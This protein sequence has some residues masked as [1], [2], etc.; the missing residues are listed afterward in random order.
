MREIRI[1]CQGSD[2]RTLEQL[3]PLQGDLKTMTKA[4]A[5]KLERALVSKGFRFPIFVW[6][7]PSR[8]IERIIDGHQRQRILTKLRD[9]GWRIPPLPVNMIEAEDEAEARQMVLA[10]VSQFGRIDIDELANFLPTAELEVADILA[11]Y[12]LPDIDEDALRALVDEMSNG[13]GD[14]D[15]ESGDDEVPDDVPTR[16]HLGVV[17]Q[18]GEHRL[19]CGDCRDPKVLKALMQGAAAKLAVHDPPYGVSIVSGTYGD[20]KMHG[21]AKAKRGNYM[22]I[23]GDDEP[24]DP[25]VLLGSAKTV[26]IWGGNY[27]ADKLPPSA[28]WLVWDKRV[29]LPSIAFAD[30]ELAWCSDDRPARVL[31]YVWGGFIKGEE[32]GEKRVHPTQKPVAL[33]ADV[34]GRYTERDDIVIDY[35]LGSGTTL[36]ACER[37]A[38]ICY[39]TELEPHYCD[40][41]VNRWEKL[42]GKKAELVGDVSGQTNKEQ[43]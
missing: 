35:Y 10:A 9:A 24:F 39:G 12:R 5:E 43:R 33:I 27:F 23:A 29:E 26:V 6:R 18:L 7:D 40:V 38:R 3:V 37:T 2:L 31:R 8:G 20:G 11:D 42:T 16:S 4:D 1:A 17:W 28:C 15:G 30:C 36:I 41:I 34:I 14:F 13:G 21:N 22:P 25:S 32:T 19:A